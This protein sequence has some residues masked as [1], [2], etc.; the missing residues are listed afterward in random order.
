MTIATS[1]VSNIVPKELAMNKRAFTWL[2]LAW[3]AISPL[4]AH[5][6]AGAKPDAEALVASK[7]SADMTYRELMQ[8]LGRSLTW[9][10][11]GI[12]LENKQLVREG[13]NHV[14]HHPAPSHK[15][16]T[17]MDKA[18]QEGF[19]QALLAYDPVLDI[20]AKEAAAAVEKSD[21]I[22]ATA[23]AARLQT[24]CVSC[25]AQWKQKAHR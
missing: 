14:I 13:V 11:T 22:E 7:R 8:I 9:I 23:A 20:H 19:K 15:P 12:V 10:Q 18:D 17:I 24:A 16:W 2:A 6:E 5:A 1:S 3:L 21:W 25:H 4:A